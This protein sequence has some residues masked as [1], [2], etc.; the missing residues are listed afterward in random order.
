MTVMMS[1]V[2]LICFL[3]TDDTLKSA[4]DWVLLKMKIGC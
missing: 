2:D 1:I 4:D 3:D